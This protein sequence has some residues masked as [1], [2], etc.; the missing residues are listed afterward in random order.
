[1]REG[2]YR[3]RCEEEEDGSSRDDCHQSESD[4]DENAVTDPFSTSNEC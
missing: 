1:M 4:I 3:S 2:T